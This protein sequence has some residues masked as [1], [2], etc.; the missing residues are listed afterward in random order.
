MNPPEDWTEIINK[1]RYATKTSLL[2]AGDDIWDGQSW[3]RKGR[4][5]FLYRTQKGNFFA[6]HLSR[7]KGE[8]NHLEPLNEDE[9]ISL[10]EQLPEKRLSFEEAFPD[11]EIE[12][13]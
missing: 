8:A 9:A 2:L 12:D 1:K 7:W 6:I 10:Y 3:E 5:I 13:A 11:V 4:N